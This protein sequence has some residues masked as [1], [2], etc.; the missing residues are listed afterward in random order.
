M[1]KRLLYLLILIVLNVTIAKSQDLMVSPSDSLILDTTISCQSEVIMS[2]SIKNNTINA[3]QMNWRFIYSTLPHGWS[4]GFCDPLLCRSGMSQISTGIKQFTLDSAALGYMQFE[5]TPISGGASGFF[6]IFMWAS[7]DSANT[8]KFLTYNISA[9]TPVNCASGITEN[10]IN[11]ISIY[12]NP[13]RNDLK[14]TLPQN[15]SNGQIDLYDLIGS[16]VYS[17]P[18]NTTKD[19]DVSALQ[20]GIYVARISENGSIIATRKFTKVD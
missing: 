10:E 12:P 16:K 3:L 9:T 18:L 19:L 17:Q 14:V 20:T 2:I 4:I 1:I 11:Q 13:V 5:P 7:N 6:Q 8:A 15:L